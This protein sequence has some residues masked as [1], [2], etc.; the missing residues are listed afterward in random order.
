[1]LNILQISFWK[2]LNSMHYVKKH[3]YIK[4]YQNIGRDNSVFHR[5]WL[6]LVPT[7]PMQTYALVTLSRPG[8]ETCIGPQPTSAHLLTQQ[9]GDETWLIMIDRHQGHSALPYRPTPS[10]FIHKNL[11]LWQFWTAVFFLLSS[12]ASD[13][14][15]APV[16]LV[17]TGY[18]PALIRILLW[19]I[20][21]N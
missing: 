5:L 7:V 8:R 15:W 10:Y 2:I 13:S 14:I 11:S 4:Q 9:R 19:Y 6:W 20:I 18:N 21:L 16:Q 1:M 3:H 17:G 12:W